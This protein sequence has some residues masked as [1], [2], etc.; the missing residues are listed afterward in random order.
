MLIKLPK[1]IILGDRARDFYK[2]KE[3]YPMCLKCV[4]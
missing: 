4:E 1:Y 2:G 3:R